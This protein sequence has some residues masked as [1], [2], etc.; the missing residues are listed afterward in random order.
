MVLDDEQAFWD[1]S[2]EVL[3]AKHQERETKELEIRHGV[4]LPNVPTLQLLPDARSLYLQ[5][6]AVKAK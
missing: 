4:E 6:V 3:Q 2:W 1:Q 5:A